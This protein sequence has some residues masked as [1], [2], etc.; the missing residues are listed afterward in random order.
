MTFGERL[1]SLRKE[2]KMTLETVAGYLGVGRATVLRY[3]NGMITNI[4]SDKIEIMAKLFDVSPAYLMGWTDDPSGVSENRPI[5]IPDSV[6]FRKI[7]KYMSYND[8]VI[9]MEA[10][11]RTYEKMKKMGVVE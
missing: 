8:Y 4:P 5:V 11:E 3:E 9:V 6:A 10:F 2:H 7:V 1:R